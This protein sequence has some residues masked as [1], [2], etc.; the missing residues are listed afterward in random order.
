MNEKRLNE[1]MILIGGP[2]TNLVT[3]KVNQYLPAKFNEDNY[4]KSI[5]SK[6]NEYTDDTCGL[7]IKTLNPFNKDKFILLL[8]GLRVT[9]TKSCII[10]LMNQCSELLKG[11]DRGSLSRV[12]KGYDFDGDGKIDGVEILE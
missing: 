10:A 5:K 3:E 2:G 9:G 1:N 12:V 8:A 7:I 11:Y 4:W 6:N